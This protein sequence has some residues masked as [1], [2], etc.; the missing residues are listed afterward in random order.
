MTDDTT[1]NRIYLGNFE[2]GTHVLVIPRPTLEAA[3]QLLDAEREKRERETKMARLKSGRRL[4]HG[5]D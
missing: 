5:P 2:G 1:K 3:E 4:A